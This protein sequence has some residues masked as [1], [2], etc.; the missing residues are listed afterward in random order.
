MKT[1]FIKLDPVVVERKVTPK[2]LSVNLK[3]S[4]AK[5]VSKDLQKLIDLGVTLSLNTSKFATLL[6]KRI[7]KNA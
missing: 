5:D 4:E 3:K 7:A 6:S 1:S 2:R